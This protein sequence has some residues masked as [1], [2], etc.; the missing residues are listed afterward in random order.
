MRLIK[1]VYGEATATL[2]LLMIA[3]V[4]VRAMVESQ[5]WWL[6]AALPW[7]VYALYLAFLMTRLVVVQRRHP[8]V[9]LSVAL[10]GVIL[11]F[12]ARP[13]AVLVAV[14]GL[15]VILGYNYWYSVQHVT[16]RPVR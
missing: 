1:A 13:L 5:P 16:A 14:L 11:A 6:A 4:V 8:W 9:Q 2:A 10:V 3:L 7:G 12:F 15:A